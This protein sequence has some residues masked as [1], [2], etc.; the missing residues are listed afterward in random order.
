MDIVIALRSPESGAAGPTCKVSLPVL[1]GRGGAHGT[2]VVREAGGGERV[3]HDFG[4]VDSKV[5]RSHV[6]VEAG[7]EG[8]VLTDRSTNG[9][10][11]RT[12][13]GFEALAPAMPVLVASN[14]E[15]EIGNAVVSLRAVSE[16]A[17]GVS[18]HML[19]ITTPSGRQL[20]LDF[21]AG[22]VV[23]G[24]SDG[25]AFARNLEHLDQID[26]AEPDWVMYLKES[27]K[28]VD[29]KVRDSA[30]RLPEFNRVPLR[31]GEVQKAEHLSVI[32]FF[33][34]R[35]VV[36]Q[37]DG[38]EALVCPNPACR[39]LNARKHGDNCRFCGAKLDTGD[40]YIVS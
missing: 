28:A 33:G 10:R 31:S 24:L 8:P 34:Q 30:S 13:S 38:P 15:L 19:N 37:K 16:G 20:E 40:T 9:T 21:A 4:I 26:T 23:L 18:A 36:W 25:R 27:G 29:L 1:I 22:A 2:L 5:S 39:L 32:D 12:G 6:L 7:P 14:T 3:L 35:V 17:P 11:R